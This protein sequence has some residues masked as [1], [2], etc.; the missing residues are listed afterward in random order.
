MYRNREKSL[1]EPDSPL[2]YVY[3]SKK[4][5]LFLQDLAANANSIDFVIVGD[6]NTGSAVAGMWGYHNG[7]Q[8][9]LHDKGYICYGTPVYP[10]MCDQTVAASLGGW[11]TGYD[12]Y[13]AGTPLKSGN[14]SGT[15]TAYSAWSPTGYTTLD[16][17]Y[18]RYGTN[19]SSSGG[20]YTDSWAYLE[21]GSAQYFNSY[22][23]AITAEHPLA[24]AG[25]ALRYRIRHG[26]FVS[27]GTGGFCPI[28]LSGTGSVNAGGAEVTTRKFVSS[29]GAADT[30]SV[31]ETAWTTSNYTSY[32]AAWAFVGPA[33]QQTK[34]PVAIHTASIYAPRK[35]WA[36]TSFCYLGGFSSGGIATVIDGVKL[37]TLKF[38]LRELRERQIAAGGTGRVVIMAQ[39]GVNAYVGN[40]A[41]TPT[42]WTDAHKSIWNSFKTAWLSLGYPIT[43]LA[44][45]S[46]CSHPVDAADNSSLGIGGNMIAVRAAANKMAQD[47]PD[48]TVIDIKKILNY[49]Q[50]ITGVG[51]GQT[52]FQY[53][54]NSPF[55]FGNFPAH[56]AG[57]NV[58]V[59][60]EVIATTSV[61]TATSIVLTG[62][63][64]AAGTVNNFYANK[65]LEI[66]KVGWADAP[67]N[68]VAFLKP[69]R[70]NIT[71][72]D[73]ATKIAKV[74]AWNGTQ[75][76]NGTAVG[77]R[78]NSYHF[79]DGYTAYMNSMLSALET[80]NL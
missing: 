71:E 47:N 24:A 30:Y 12:L 11:R 61:T 68:T 23:V 65:E 16:N 15:A 9:A 70:V 73:A 42:K 67:T 19:T 29:E 80:V 62:A 58:S 63:Y 17:V 72:Y 54:N 66:T 34:G 75:P 60:A 33:S 27:A 7:L 35:G 6:S 56:L 26:T 18:V 41:E 53:F 44:I 38:N 49:K 2:T 32:R 64:A 40:T 13:P 52:Y 36:V 37:S 22:G 74:A 10:A 39:S 1:T 79:C 5:S 69:Q 43:D 3:G 4:A 31:N 57:G 78:I 14:I 46:W 59:G 8:Q 25:T 48:M 50:L 20:P 28:V 21:P 51:T 45:V 76:T 55:V 77:Y